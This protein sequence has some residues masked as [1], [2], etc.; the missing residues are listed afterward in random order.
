M[1]KGATVSRTTWVDH[2]SLGIPGYDKLQADDLGTGAP[3]DDGSHGQG[4]DLKVHEFRLFQQFSP[5]IYKLNCGLIN[6]ASP[7][8][9]H[10]AIQSVLPAAS[11]GPASYLP[12][13]LHPGDV[14]KPTSSP[15]DLLPG[16]GARMDIHSMTQSRWRT[17]QPTSSTEPHFFSKTGTSASSALEFPSAQLASNHEAHTSFNLTTKI[18][19]ES[20]PTCK[21][22]VS[23]VRQV[24]ERQHP[25]H[26]EQQVNNVVP[27]LHI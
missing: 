16:Q 17:S 8:S 27:I 15:P 18:Q 14:S 20:R 26:P 3:G 1:V 24:S 7:A 6:S 2:L 10:S 22:S 11:L 13:S 12:A 19:Q 23:T 25:H 21:Y 5:G 4:R 9:C